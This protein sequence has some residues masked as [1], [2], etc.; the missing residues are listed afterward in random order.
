MIQAEDTNSTFEHPP[1]WDSLSNQEKADL[2]VINNMSKLICMAYF[3]SHYF[4]EVSS[5]ST[6]IEQ[7]LNK[8][9]RLDI[10]TPKEKRPD[11]DNFL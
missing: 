7:I 10:N 6:S 11:L 5:Q 3:S 2:I 1:N 8:D 4:K 9:S